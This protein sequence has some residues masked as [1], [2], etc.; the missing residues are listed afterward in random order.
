MKSSLASLYFEKNK[1]S[2]SSDLWGKATIAYLQDQMILLEAIE[3]MVSFLHQKK[4]QTEK[5]YHLFLRRFLSLVLFCLN[6]KEKDLSFFKPLIRKAQSYD[7]FCWFLPAKYIK[8]LI[9][10]LLKQED[11]F[12]FSFIDD[13]ILLAANKSYDLHYQVPNFVNWTEMTSVAL[14]YGIVN[15]DENLLSKA[16]KS[17]LMIANFIDSNNFPTLS[18]WISDTQFDFMQSLCF[19]S[20]LFEA[21]HNL[22]STSF[23]KVM[24]RLLEEIKSQ[25][26]QIFLF[27]VILSKWLK[28]FSYKKE[29]IK[30]P[31]AFAIPSLATIGYRGEEAFSSFTFAGVNSGIGSI[32]IADVKILSFGPQ[33]YPLGEMKNYGIFRQIHDSK[34]FD[35]IKVTMNKDFSSI[36]GWTRLCIEKQSESLGAD[37]WL[38]LKAKVNDQYTKL[39]FDFAEQKINRSLTFTFYIK[40]KS[41][42]VDDTTLLPSSLD[43]FEGKMPKQLSFRG[44]KGSIS[45]KAKNEEKVHIIPLAGENCFWNAN[46]L[47]AIDPSIH[48]GACEINIEKV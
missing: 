1:N 29:D 41:C 16:K 26:R 2:V 31:K 5:D 47:L 13:S 38:N 22:L 11:D 15:Q 14:L 35:D 25:N 48:K 18:L 8:N 4:I 36:Q 20:L 3:E 42:L 19:F 10:S 32:H 17:A 34:S 6:Q 28:N 37:L 43:R 12:T 40:A 30:L 46:F 23:E 9:F 39:I 7:Y 45:I 21:V 44:K 27:P 33:T 24:L